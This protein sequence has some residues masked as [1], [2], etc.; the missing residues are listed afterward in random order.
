MAMDTARKKH[1]NRFEE[2]EKLFRS[3]LETSNKADWQ[4]KYFIPRTY[5]MVMASLSEFAI[6]K[7][8]IIVEPDTRSDAMSVP[9]MRAVLHANWRKN[10]GNA[11]LL[12]LLLD[13]LKLGIGILEVGYRKDLREIKEITG[14]D[15]VSEQIEWKKKEIYDFDDVYFEAVNPRY[16]W[17]DE[18]AS[19]I[20]DAAD[21]VRQYIY[22]EQGFHQIFDSKFPRAKTVKT[23]GEVIKEEFF[24][25]FIGSGTNTNEICVFKYTNKVKDVLWWI[26]DGVL[27]NE[28]DDPMP[29]H[30]KQLNYAEVKLAPYDKYTF[31]GLS[32]PGIIKDIQNELNT[33]RNM[34]IDQT[35]LNIFSPFFYSADEDLD[36]SIF[37]IEPGVGIPVSDPNNFTFFK[38]R[39]MG[40]DVYQMMDRF[41]DDA[42]QA[43]GFDMRLQSSRGDETATKTTVIKET[44][45]KRIN[46]YLR[47]LEDFS[48]PDFAS[49]WGDTIQQFY[50]MSSDTKTK[51]IRDRS[52][53]NA[54]KEKVFR[55]I[56]IP[57]SE[58]SEVRSVESVSG[59]NF[60]DVTPEDIRGKFDY[61]IKIG[62]TIAI[63]KEL[64]KQIK[65]QLYSILAAEPLVRR[66][67]LVID[68]LK[69]HE[70]DPEEYMGMSPQVDQ[71]EAVALA[72]EQNKQL[73]A[74]EKPTIIPEL[75]TPEHIQVHDALIKSGQVDAETKSRI[76]AHVMEEM[77]IA[78][79]GGAK[80]A[81]GEP[82]QEMLAL[83]REPQLTEPLAK[84]PGLTKG[85]TRPGTAAE[86]TSKTA[87]AVTGPAV[88]KPARRP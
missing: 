16:F 74:G 71:M 2:D 5:G 15:A 56:K 77:R 17:V 80:L 72:E 42:E 25:P 63:S 78:K 88:N 19:T 37:T 87:P 79:V 31:Y 11:E 45:L 81:A 68:L 54:E 40:Q 39:Q 73:I 66:E 60:L 62:T 21:C 51:K 20:N 26:A 58:I 29:Y 1:Y 76:Q 57:K 84:M 33:L 8:D 38:Q 3:H 75:I 64:T 10:K 27:L 30:H 46:L 24:K 22:S 86:I 83:E 35:H 9:Y 12:F 43:T 6:N 34:G 47:F 49:L 18:S 36:E 61:N 23:K 70:L 53:G 28:A 85:V 4:S 32:L 67:K 44:S 52:K 50:F 82:S 55:S 59:F 14:Y 7:P 65:L 13:A 69:S 41:D 48:M